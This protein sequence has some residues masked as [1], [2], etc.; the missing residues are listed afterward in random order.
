LVVVV[1]TCAIPVAVVVWC[2]CSRFGRRKN[3]YGSESDA[4][5]LEEIP[6]GFSSPAYTAE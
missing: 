2:I 6:E 4:S 1:L 3:V 5:E